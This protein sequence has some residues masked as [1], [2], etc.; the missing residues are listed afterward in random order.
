MNEDHITDLFK[1]GNESNDE[2]EQLFF[3]SKGKFII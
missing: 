2:N 1:K 3:F